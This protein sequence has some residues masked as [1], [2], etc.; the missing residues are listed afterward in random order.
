MSKDPENLYINC[1]NL[2]LMAKHTMETNCVTPLGVTQFGNL[3]TM[4]R[5]P[6]DVTV[7]MRALHIVS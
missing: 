5:L 1:S 7:G 6:S 2:C 3:G 4:Q